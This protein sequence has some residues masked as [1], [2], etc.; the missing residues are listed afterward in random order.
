MQ[1]WPRTGAWDAYGAHEHRPMPSRR[2]PHAGKIVTASGRPGDS[3][4]LSCADAGPS[5]AGRS[6]AR[7]QPVVIK[8]RV[9]LLGKP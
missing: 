3:T 6:P 2:V 8:S 7:P 4:V 5:A 9:A 1:R